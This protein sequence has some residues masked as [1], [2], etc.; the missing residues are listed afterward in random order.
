MIDKRIYYCQFGDKEMSELNKKCMASQTKFCPD[1]E[2]VKIDETNFDWKKTDYT[3]EGYEKKNWS[4]VTNAAR[5]DVLRR[6]NGFYL[7][8]DVQLLKSLDEL[9]VLD[10]GFIT[11]FEPSQPDSGVL[12]CGDKFPQLYDVAEKELVKGSVLHKNFIRNLYKMYNYHGQSKVTFKDGFTI[13]GEEWFPTIR[14][15]FITDK[16]IAIHY[17]EN[18]Q[19][20][21]P[22]N[23][24]DPFYPFQKVD[25]YFAGRKIHEDE[26]STIKLTIFTNK[27]WKSSDI[28]GR[29]NYF[30]NP[31][32]VKVQC[33]D[34]VA[35][36]KDWNKLA[37]ICTDVTAGGFVVTYMI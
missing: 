17:F 33:R 31:N 6:G 14:S 10:G 35:E 3:I 27:E 37:P 24:T 25:V 2:I 5:L 28:L 13:L 12:G 4:A 15:K 36:R 23:I 22:I 30:F 16:T 29:M 32:V 20:K 18:T 21:T 19:V 26:D 9:R 11:E 1:Y 7:D 34:F 8:T